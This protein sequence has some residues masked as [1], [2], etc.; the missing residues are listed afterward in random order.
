MSGH[1]SQLLQIIDLLLAHTSTALENKEI[2][3]N[4]NDD[5]K[6]YILEHGTDLKY[7]ARPLRRA[8]QKLIEDEIAEMVLRNQVISGQTVYVFVENGNLKFDA[9]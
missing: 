8:I 3:L 4:V 9:N 7:G 6:N 2:H 5:A 1:K